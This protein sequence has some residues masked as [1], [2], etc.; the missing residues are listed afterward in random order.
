MQD[1]IPN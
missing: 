1:P